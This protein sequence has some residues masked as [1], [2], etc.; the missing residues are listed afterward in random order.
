MLGR[1][2]SPEDLP[3]ALSAPARCDLTVVGGGIVG[4]AVARELARRFPS[5]SICVLER[6]TELGQH[7]TSH[8]SGVI[9]AGV[10]YKPGSSKARLCVE[11]AAELY[12][13]CEEREIPH[14]RCGKL[15]VAASDEE[16]S[17][18]EELQRR[19]TLNGVS[20]LRRLDSEGIRELEPHVRGVAGLHCPPTGIVDFHAVAL[21]YAHDLLEA[22]GTLVTGC[23]VRAVEHRGRGLRLLHAH[24]FTDTSTPSSAAG[25][26]R[27]VSRQRRAP[28]GIPASSLFSAAT[29][30][31]PKSAE[32]S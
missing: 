9:H 3:A 23:E 13:Y 22:D 29:C 32:A 6:E 27:T 31:L 4:L 7:Q 11:G 10:Y 25:H 12:D 30:A 15:I 5:S 26:G 21:A 17:R 28:P 16:I 1:L 2:P 24:G 8:N 19:G 14:E 20:G 18:L